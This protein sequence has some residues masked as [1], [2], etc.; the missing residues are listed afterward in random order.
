MTDST[1]LDLERL[2]EIYEDDSEGIRDVLELTV[3]MT[4]TQLD[5]VSAAVESHDAPGVRSAAHAIKG[6]ASNVGATETARL[7]AALEQAAIAAAWDAIPAA[8][9][10]L[11][12]GF[13]RL[14]TSIAGFNREV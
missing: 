7:A 6:A 1:I 3:E 14:E 11:C 9:T 4:K 2:R 10:A 5:A 12:E 13:A 8:F